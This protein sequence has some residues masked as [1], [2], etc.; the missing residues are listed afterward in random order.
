MPLESD[1]G[2]KMLQ[3]HMEYE[4]CGFQT[5]FCDYYISTLH[6]E[7]TVST[8]DQL[9]LEIYAFVISFRLVILSI[10]QRMCY[11]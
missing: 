3:K 7:T 6:L 5:D 1:S 9:A 2:L 8:L 10:N 11:L 4:K